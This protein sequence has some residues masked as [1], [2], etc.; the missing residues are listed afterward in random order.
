MS[1]SEDIY[2]KSL[3]KKT[4]FYFFSMKSFI[5]LKNYIKTLENQWF[6]RIAVNADLVLINSSV[7]F[8][9][10]FVQIQIE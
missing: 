7:I 5:Y 8:E 3:L 9:C 4:S 10:I 2:F 6:I 1:E